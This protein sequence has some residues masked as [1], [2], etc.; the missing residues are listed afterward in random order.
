MVLHPPGCGRVGHHRAHTS[1]IGSAFTNDVKAAP[2]LS[3]LLFAQ[4][5][6]HTPSRDTRSAECGTERRAPH[7]CYRVSLRPWPEVRVGSSQAINDS[8]GTDGSSGAKEGPWR[9]RI[10]GTTRITATQVGV[11]ETVIV[12]ASG[13]ASVLKATTRL[14]AGPTTDTESP[15]TLRGVLGVRI[16]TSAPLARTVSSGTTGGVNDV[17]MGASVRGALTE[18]AGGQVDST[19]VP[20]G[21][22]AETGAMII[23]VARHSV[24]AFPSLLCRT[25]SN[26]Q[27]SSGAPGTSCVPWGEPTPRT[28]PVIL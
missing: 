10:V 5:Q 12:T 6:G 17:E 20:G 9:I 24:S 21:G 13:A 3:F 27:T 19:T 4:C 23:A 8:E 16:M 11:V 14:G 28:S 22:T 18:A 26:P 1:G 7:P 2:I 15:L 25:R